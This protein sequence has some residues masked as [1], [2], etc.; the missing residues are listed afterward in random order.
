MPKLK[1]D[2][3]KITKWHPEF[4]LENVPDIEEHTLPK[5]PEIKTVTSARDALE[6]ARVA[7]LSKVCDLC[8]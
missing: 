8:L 5:A 1:L 2:L 4:D 6:I 3:S 7:R